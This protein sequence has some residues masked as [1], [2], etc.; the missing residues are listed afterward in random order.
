MLIRRDRGDR[1]NTDH[2]TRGRPPDDALRGGHHEAINEAAGERVVSGAYLWLLRTWQRDNRTMKHVIVIARFFS[3]PPTYFFPD[4]AMQQDA[5][6]AELA[7]ALSDD[8]VREMALRTAGLSDR[9]L[10][11][12]TDMINNARTVEELPDDA[13]SEDWQ[14]QAIAASASQSWSPRSFA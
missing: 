4:D 6:P 13:S 11:A 14:G 1:R 10:M 8:H 9:S 2:R 3:V 12:I 7:A 5:V